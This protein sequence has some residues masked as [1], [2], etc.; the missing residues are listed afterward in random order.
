MDEKRRGADDVPSSDRLIAAI[1]GDQD[2]RTTRQQLLHAGVSRREVDVRRDCGQLI[3]KYRGYYSVGHDAQSR[4]ADLRTATH[5]GRKGCAVS[6]LP[7]LERHGYIDRVVG[8]IDVTVPKKK[9]RRKGIRWHRDHMEADEWGYI[10]GI[11]VTCR[12]R[13]LRDCAPLLGRERLDRIFDRV[14]DDLEH[15]PITFDDL[16]ARY[17]RHPGSRILRQLLADRSEGKTRSW[18]EAKFTPVICGLPTPERNKR[19]P[20]KN[21]RTIEGDCVWGRLIAELDGRTYHERQA[22]FESDRKRDA[23]ALASGY[24][25]MRITWSRLRD[26]PDRVRRDLE[27]AIALLGT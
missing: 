22:A 17:P 10:D 26:E 6:H 20:L 12:I 18:L 5:I 1:A 13:T 21:G 3:V 11:P 4:L 19:I 8:P 16:F 9:R 7:G 14:Q 25:T 23:A 27:D 2:G 15:D 24:M